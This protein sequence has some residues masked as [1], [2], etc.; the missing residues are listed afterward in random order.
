MFLAYT[1]QHPLLPKC[2]RLSD[3]A[4]HVI[5]DNS[6]NNFSTAKSF[7]KNME[8]PY[9]EFEDL[10]L[11]EFLAK[12]PHNSL[13]SP[14]EKS[15]PGADEEDDMTAVS[16]TADYGSS[17]SDISP[18]ERLE[19]IK[20]MEVPT[21]GPFGGEQALLDYFG[22]EEIEQSERAIEENQIAGETE[23]GVFQ[24][25]GRGP[26]SNWM[27]GGSEGE[28]EEV[29]KAQSKVRMPNSA[30]PKHFPTF[31]LYALS[32]VCMKRLIIHIHRLDSDSP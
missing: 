13:P 1:H 29:K 19:E 18:Y 24:Q 9:R 6:N 27:L 23:E 25:N 20:D 30:I 2:H 31:H 16:T 32:G 17:A 3:L 26:S 15:T 14:S 28:N 7:Y 21:K 8:N 22:G 4:S 12:I 10:S 5:M 11:G